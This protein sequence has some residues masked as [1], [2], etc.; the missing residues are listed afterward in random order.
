MAE[1]LGMSLDDLIAK[2]TSSYGPNR[3]SN[4][5][6]N[7]DTNRRAVVSKP[8]SRN[9]R[10][11]RGGVSQTNRVYVGNLPFETTWQDLKDHLKAWNVTFAE[12]MLDQSGRSKGWGIA[13]FASAADANKAISELQNAELGGRKL[14][15]REDREAEN[16]VESFVPQRR[17]QRNY[18]RA[19]DPAFGRQI[20]F[21]NLSYETSWQDLKDICRL[22]GDVERADIAFDEAGRSRGYGLVLFTTPGAAQRAINRFNGSTLQGRVITV[23]LDEFV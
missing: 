23:K 11:E 7:R 10:V 13:E 6:S 9:P 3:R 5:F 2:N 15:V 22:C 18:Q 8:Y 17:N 19:E 1:G 16:V 14:I 21:G 20:H 12:V 4:R